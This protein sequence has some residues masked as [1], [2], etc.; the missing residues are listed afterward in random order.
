MYV[1]MYIYIYTHIGE[2]VQ[3][4]KQNG[5]GI[6]LSSIRSELFQDD[7]VLNLKVTTSPPMLTMDSSSAM[8]HS[9]FH[10]CEVKDKVFNTLDRGREFLSVLEDLIDLDSPLHLQNKNINAKVTSKG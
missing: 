2:R 9:D 5:I 4:S 8:N 3:T 10:T 7:K 1:C 6:N